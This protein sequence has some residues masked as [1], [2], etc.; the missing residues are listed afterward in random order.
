M[1]NDTINA[2]LARGPDPS[3]AFAAEF[4]GR[5]GIDVMTHTSLERPASLVPCTCHSG[6]GESV[7]GPLLMLHAFMTTRLAES[8]LSGATTSAGDE[9]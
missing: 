8:C 7:F 6:Y 1:L 9:V 2:G 3:P 5:R 4:Q